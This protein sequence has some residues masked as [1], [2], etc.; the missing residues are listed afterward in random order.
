MW[1]L[2]QEELGGTCSARHKGKGPPSGAGSPQAS[3][4]G[5]AVRAIMSLNCL[6]RK[7]SLALGPVC[8]LLF[9]GVALLLLHRAREWAQIQEQKECQELIWLLESKNLFFGNF[10]YRKTSRNQKRIRA[11]KKW[12]I[13]TEDK[14]ILE[15][16]LLT[17]ECQWDPDAAVVAQYRAELG[18]C[19]NA[20]SLLILTKENTPLGSNIVF[21]KDGRK[22]PVR[23]EL[24]DLL[25]ERSTFSEV[26]YE[27]CAVVGNGGILQRSRCG[28]EID[29]ADFVIRFSLPPARNSSEDVGSKTS[30]V[31][32]NLSSLDSKYQGSQRKRLADA[33]HPYRDTLLLLLPTLQSRARKPPLHPLEDSDVLQGASFLN[34]QYLDALGSYWTREGFQPECLSPNFAFV[35]L[36]L[37]L[38]QRI[39]LYGFWPFAHSLSGQPFPRHS[40]VRVRPSEFSCYLK[41]YLQGILR[42]R[43]GKCQ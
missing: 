40:Q 10:Q 9:L 17:E 15:H 38:C 7:W 14:N 37:Q 5:G 20:S 41:M 3:P 30:L 12:D 13:W 31:A 39:T 18:Q 28:K 2:G 21:G 4:W 26:Q 43:L 1:G 27:H 35:S 19:C 6:P 32:L 25:P 16:V 23:P 22:V 24:V 36:A 8:L 34:P 29:Q 11:V 42:L 33:L